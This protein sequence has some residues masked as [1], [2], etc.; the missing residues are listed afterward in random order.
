M[1]LRRSF[2]HQATACVL[3]LFLATANAA[4]QNAAN[5][6]SALHYRA[7]Q[8]QALERY[9]EGLAVAHQLEALVKAT[10]GLRPRF[11]AIALEMKAD[12]LSHMGRNNESLD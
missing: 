2:V 9:E 12:L 8:L 11:Y 10:P 7:L 4:A 3:F 6:F 5:E 1:S